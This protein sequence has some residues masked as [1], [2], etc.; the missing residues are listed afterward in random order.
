MKMNTFQDVTIFS[1]TKRVTT[2]SRLEIAA[3]IPFLRDV[4]SSQN[5]CDGCKENTA[6]V[7]AEED[8]DTLK[9]TFGHLSHLASGFQREFSKFLRERDSADAGEKNR[10][11]DLMLTISLFKG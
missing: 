2:A 8:E 7:F 3:N 1:G 9:A 10:I 11:D 4:L 5:L 6:L